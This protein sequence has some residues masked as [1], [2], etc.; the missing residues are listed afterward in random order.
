MHPTHRHIQP[1]SF[2]YKSGNFDALD[3]ELSMDPI[4]AVLFDYNT[5]QVLWHSKPGSSEGSFS[6]VS[7]GKFHFCLG[8]GTGGYKTPEDI[9]RQKYKLQGHPSPQDDDF[10][11][12]NEDGQNR[13][14]GFAIHVHPVQGTKFHDMQ[15][16]K[17][18]TEKDYEEDHPMTK[19]T[20][21]AGQLTDRIETLLDHQEYIK[22][23]ESLHRH[24]VE[25]TFS[26]VMRWTVLEA[27]ILIGIACAQVYYLMKFFE[28]KRYL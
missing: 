9:E 15:L 5:D 27:L 25:G 14:I 6:M 4:T 13:R 8:N 1:L 3:D 24:V 2:F 21:L 23:R 7:S 28:T 26:M 17:N 20:N 16:E 22:S 18:K 10:E 12:A 19:L 11:Y